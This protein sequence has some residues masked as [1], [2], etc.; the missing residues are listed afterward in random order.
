[1]TIFVASH[2]PVPFTGGHSESGNGQTL[3][4]VESLTESETRGTWRI[5]E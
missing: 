2:L 5:F 1:V 3:V 4:C